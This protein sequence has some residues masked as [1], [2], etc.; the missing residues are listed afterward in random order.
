MN[1]LFYNVMCKSE[2]RVVVTPVSI[3]IVQ[4]VFGIACGVGTRFG[5]SVRVVW[6][7][8]HTR[9]PSTSTQLKC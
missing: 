8:T 9:V 6:N 4:L 7:P 3:V 2:L 5:V 1:E